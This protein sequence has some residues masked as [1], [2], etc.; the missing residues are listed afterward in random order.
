M[1]GF[2]PRP[3]C[4]ADALAGS[5]EFFRYMPFRRQL[6]FRGSAGGCGPGSEDLGAPSARA[7]KRNLLPAMDSLQAQGTP[8]PPPPGTKRN[9][10]RPPEPASVLAVEKAVFFFLEKRKRKGSN[11]S[12]NKAGSNSVRAAIIP[13]PRLGRARPFFAVAFLCA[14]H[15]RWT[16]L[17]PAAVAPSPAGSTTSS[18]GSDLDGP[19]SRRLRLGGDAGPSVSHGRGSPNPGSHP[20]QGRSSADGRSVI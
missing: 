14:V 9:L 1:D 4:L 12:S 20:P 13:P 18:A 17:A 5:L 19:A 10:V 7:L 8:C 16:A 6:D 3:P 15:R 11:S 2:V